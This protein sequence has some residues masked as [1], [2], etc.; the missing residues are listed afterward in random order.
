MICIAEMTSEYSICRTCGTR[1]PNENMESIYNCQEVASKFRKL[2]PLNIVLDRRLSEF[3]CKPCIMELN[4]THEFIEKALAMQKQQLDEVLPIKKARVESEPPATPE[5]PQEQPAE[6]TVDKQPIENLPDKSSLTVPEK[7]VE[8]QKAIEKRAASPELILVE[9]EPEAV[10]PLPPTP[11]RPQL[12]LKPISSLMNPSAMVPL[13]QPSIPTQ[14]VRPTVQSMPRECRCDRCYTVVRVEK[15]EAHKKR[16]ELRGTRLIMPMQQPNQAPANNVILHQMSTTFNQIEM[17]T[18]RSLQRVVSSISPPVYSVAVASRSVQ[19]APVATQPSLYP[20]TMSTTAVSNM[21]GHLPSSSSPRTRQN[22]P[23]I[24]PQPYYQGG[25]FMAQQQANGNPLIQNMLP[26][27]NPPIVEQQQ[28][29][30]VSATPTPP[31]PMQVVNPVNNATPSEQPKVPD[32]CMDDDSNSLEIVDYIQTPTVLSTFSLAAQAADDKAEPLP[33]QNIVD[34]PPVVPKCEEKTADAST[35]LNVKALMALWSNPDLNTS[36][37]FDDKLKCKTLF[38]EC[39]NSMCQ[40]S[41]CRIFF[42]NKAE[43]ILHLTT[44]LH[45][46]NFHKFFPCYACKI[47]FANLQLLKEHHAM[48]L[49]GNARSQYSCSLCPLFSSKEENVLKHMIKSHCFCPHCHS[50]LQKLR[51]VQLSKKSRKLESHKCLVCGLLINRHA[52]LAMLKC[53]ELDPNEMVYVCNFCSI[54]VSSKELL[55]LHF[56]QNHSSVFGGKKFEPF[57][58]PNMVAHFLPYTAEGT[59]PIIPSSSSNSVEK[60]IA[61]T[62]KNATTVV[63]PAKIDSDAKC[64][65]DSCESVKSTESVPAIKVEKEDAPDKE[66]K[67]TDESIHYCCHECPASFTQ[68]SELIFHAK[69]SHTKNHFKCTICNRN[70]AS[71]VGLDS[72][73]CRDTSGKMVLKLIKMEDLQN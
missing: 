50:Y 31:P 26:H 23:Q 7:P 18:I 9:D 63:T 15:Y 52:A 73:K 12:K 25:Y 36:S 27:A 10:P 16:C 32:S 41:I 1:A 53:T 57:E 30:V 6:K 61:P 47:N 39:L 3:M 69:H 4:L 46:Q 44:D 29:Q 55:T 59:L 28:Q 68:F 49:H 24:I 21:V 37:I 38:N 48:G 56:Q 35:S 14:Q 66:K 17:P 43:Y 58:T 64:Q 20:N 70:F 72:H 45:G 22:L 19:S 51:Y 40:C 11:P 67:K 54:S 8:A 5:K 62:E 13:T 34:Q 71:K 42:L 65:R 33:A 60:E 2:L